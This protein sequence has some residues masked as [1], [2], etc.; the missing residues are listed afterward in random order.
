MPIDKGLAEAHRLEA[1]RA[2]AARTRERRAAARANVI[3]CAAETVGTLTGRE[4]LFIGLALSGRGG[5]EQAMGAARTHW[6]FNSDPD[7][8]QVFMRW[9]DLLGVDRARCR[10]HLSICESARTSRAPK[11]S[12]PT[13]S[14][15]MSDVQPH[16]HQAPQPKERA[17]QHRRCIEA[18]RRCLAVGRP[19][20]PRW[21]WWRGIVL[22]A[23]APEAINGL[24]CRQ[25]YPGSSRGRTG[26]LWSTG[27]E[28]RILVREQH[29]LGS[30]RR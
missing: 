4:L 29:G 17:V 3:A 9:L 18:L 27:I 30:G 5:K 23:R 8:I 12:G 19:L 10:F 24:G 14:A 1:V 7:V 2:A 21:G 26:Q 22:G 13:L 20:P 15:S 16:Q 25:I 6:L 28:V 11:P